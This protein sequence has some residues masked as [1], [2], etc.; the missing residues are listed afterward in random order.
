M[1]VLNVSRHG[2]LIEGDPLPEAG[3][4]I[5]MGFAG[6]NPVT[7]RITW[8]REGRAGVEFACGTSVIVPAPAP[9]ESISGHRLSN[10]MLLPAL[11]PRPERHC[12]MWQCTLYWD[13]GSAAARLRNISARGAMVVGPKNLPLGSPIVL[14]LKGAGTAHGSV[15]WCRAGQIGLRFDR[16]FDLNKLLD[17]QGRARSA[18]SRPGILKPLYLQSELDPGSPWAARWERLKPEDL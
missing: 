2:A 3:Q 15:R 7:C 4:S 10:S 18:A 11:A 6:C 5:T 8:V 14:V 1:F 17:R 9:R 13:G 12:L 16:Q